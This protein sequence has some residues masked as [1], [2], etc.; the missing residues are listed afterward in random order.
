MHYQINVDHT[1]WGRLK[2]YILHPC[3]NVVNYGM[4]PLKLKTSLWTYIMYFK[5][6][7]NN[8]RLIQY[9]SVTACFVNI[10]AKL[11]TAKFPV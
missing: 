6:H 2:K 8:L 3:E 10:Q 4:I 11:S 7:N 9:I 5:C 1:L